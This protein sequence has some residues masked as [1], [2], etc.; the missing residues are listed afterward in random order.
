MAE[1][2]SKEK[3]ELEEEI[4]YLSRLIESHKRESRKESEGVNAAARPNRY[5]L[6]NS[7]GASQP[8]INKPSK[9]L[10]CK[11]APF[12]GQSS[13]FLSTSTV[14]AICS[15]TFKHVATNQKC[16]LQKT[17]TMKPGPVIKSNH[18]ER[19]KPAARPSPVV[20]PNPAVRLSSTGK[21]NPTE[22]PS[23]TVKFSGAVKP[24]PVVKPRKRSLSTVVRKSRFKLQKTYAIP[25]TPADVSASPNAAGK[26]SPAATRGLPG[27]PVRRSLFPFKVGSVGRYVYRKSNVSA[28]SPH[29]FV[30]APNKPGGRSIPPRTLVSKYKLVRDKTKV[31]TPSRSLVTNLACL[32]ARRIVKKY[33]ISN[34]NRTRSSLSHSRGQSG[35]VAAPARRFLWPPSYAST[36]YFHKLSQGNRVGRLSYKKAG[37][38]ARDSRSRY[39]KIGSITYRA[40]RNKLS[41][42]RKRSLPPTPT[43]SR[44]SSRQQ[45]ILVI[46][47][48]TYHMDVSGKVL[49]RAPASSQSPGASLSRIDIGG[50]TFVERLP[51]VLSQTPSS[52]T[53]T[54]LSRTI[55]RSIHRM[56]TVNTRKLER[57]SDRYCMFF[58]RFG[59]CNKGASCTYIHDPEKIAVCT[60][61]LRGTCKLSD[62]PFSHKVAPEKMPVCSFFLKGRCTS[63][64]CPYRHVKVNAKA[65]VCRD[66]AVRGFC[67]E[68]IKCKRQHVLVCPEYA[69][70]KKCPRGNRCF[71]AHR[72]QAAKRK[73]REKSASPVDLEQRDENAEREED[74]GPGCKMARGPQFISLKPY[75]SPLCTPT[76]RPPQADQ[77]GMRIR[78]DFL[79]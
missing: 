3:R 69:A 48:T 17:S 47:G 12:R 32:G 10:V 37:T 35:H 65:E 56:R 50:K 62:C 63:N 28:A 13:S 55:N 42:T 38:E 52:E 25:S 58:N 77:K 9:N 15:S 29:R 66:F 53:R 59:R 18:D 31:Q 43:T 44:G 1:I 51:G 36:H 78:P 70:N 79:S 54:Y 20:E 8:S 76:C 7:S 6:V 39:I 30:S 64:P 34:V 26:T 67:T 2:S 75:E 49:R 24:T 14:P 40:S 16:T 41:R 72:D 68:G 74:E 21:Q 11:S 71:L 60:R 46:R 5:K 19:P 27:R 22:K 61:F 73:H 4:L 33:K 23:S 45:R 57:R